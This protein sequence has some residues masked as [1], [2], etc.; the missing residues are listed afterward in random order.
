MGAAYRP[1][2]GVGPHRSWFGS[3][4]FRGLHESPVVVRIRQS[5][6][7]AAGRKGSVLPSALRRGAV[8]GAPHRPI[9]PSPEVVLP[10]PFVMPP[11]PVTPVATRWLRSSVG[12]DGVRAR[13]SA[14][15][16][17]RA[18]RLRRSF[19]PP[20][21]PHRFFS[22]YT[23]FQT[24]A[25]HAPQRGCALARRCTTQ[26]LRGRGEFLFA[27]PRVAAARQPWALLRNAVGVKTVS[28][29]I[30]SQLNV[31]SRPHPFRSLTAAKPRALIW[32]SSEK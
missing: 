11:S 14:R 20:S 25:V 4:F 15:V 24:T 7:P 9:M 1:S 32:P 13:R 10:G 3:V 28:V 31:Q 19:R 27:I 2:D 30:S 16:R 22:R 5:A 18:G 21:T 26:P 8:I 17:S 29:R 12:S 23:E 6:W